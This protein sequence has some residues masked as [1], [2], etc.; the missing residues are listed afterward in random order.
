MKLACR[1]RLQRGRFVN[2]TISELTE[3]GHNT[4]ASWRYPPPYD[5]YAAS[6]LLGFG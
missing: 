6:A 4:M 1:E 3:E 5:F 2:L